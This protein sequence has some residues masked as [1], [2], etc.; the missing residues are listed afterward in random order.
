MTDATPRFDHLVINASKF[1]GG[2]AFHS[3]NRD[4][5]DC[6][7]GATNALRHIYARFALGARLGYC[8]A[9]AASPGRQS[10]EGL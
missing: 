4:S 8:A 3:L 5:T 6:A 2:G 1:D 9:Q 10:F 7:L